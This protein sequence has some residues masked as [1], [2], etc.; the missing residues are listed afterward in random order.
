MIEIE[1][2][3]VPAGEYPIGDNTLSAS[4]PAHVVHLE[5]FAIGLTPVTNTQF[6]AFVEAGG[7]DSPVYWGEMGWRWL[8]GQ[9]ARQPDFWH[10]RRFN[11]PDQPVVGVCWYEALAYTIWLGGVTGLPWRLPT[12]A[13]WEAAARGMDGDAPSPRL[14][15]TAER[16]LGRPWPVTKPSN[17]SWC[18]ASDLCGNVWEWC[19]SRWGHNW[20]TMEYAYP[21]DAGDGRENLSGSFARVMRGGSWF[22]PL[23]EANPANRGRYLPG[24]RGS[25]IGFR[26]ARGLV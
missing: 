13:E 1:V 10:D 24:S 22:D 20:Q 9:G 17:R 21:Y 12:E 23:K 3:E 11:A 19:S 7:Y 5:A 16:G 15:N 14:Y 18:G 6:A 26:L 25:N 8:R 4:R 2:C